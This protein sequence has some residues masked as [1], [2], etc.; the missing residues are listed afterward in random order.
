MIVFKNVSRRS[1]MWIID[2]LLQL[3]KGRFIV[4]ALIVIQHLNLDKNVDE[5]HCKHNQI[6]FLLSNDQWKILVWILNNKC[7]KTN[8]LQILPANMLHKHI[9]TLLYPLHYMLNIIY[10]TI[11]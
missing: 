7:I 3:K 10:Y 2:P 6:W 11:Y 1:I 8:V 9:Q 4:W 5:C